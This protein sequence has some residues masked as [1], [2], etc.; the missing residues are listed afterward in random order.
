MKPEDQAWQKLVATA[1]QVRDERDV[2]APYGF[3]TRVASMAMTEGRPAG[4]EALFERFSWRALLV[5]AV[6]AIGGV[7]TNYAS[8]T[9]SS[10]DEEALL[11]ETL[12]TAVF[13]L[14]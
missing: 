6:L 5:A 9:G 11:D 7:A 2:S 1:R 10:F 4:I 8:I 13:D 14:S 12:V 3:A